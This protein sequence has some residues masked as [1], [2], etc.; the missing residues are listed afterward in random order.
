MGLATEDIVRVLPVHT[1]PLGGVELEETMR[2]VPGGGEFMLDS[3]T[4]V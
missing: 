3:R 4:E 1:A 2:R